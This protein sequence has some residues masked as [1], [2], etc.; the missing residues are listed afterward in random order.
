MLELQRLDRTDIVQQRDE[1]WGI[2]FR[3]LLRLGED[4]IVG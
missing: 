4:N 1:H 3:I 2:C